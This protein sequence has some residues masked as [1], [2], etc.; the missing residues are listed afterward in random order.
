LALASQIIS[1]G[2]QKR[3]AAQVGI[4]ITHYQQRSA[5][6][7]SSTSWQQKKEAELVIGLLLSHDPRRVVSLSYEIHRQIE[8]L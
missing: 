8:V 4:G 7:V 6:E 1:R 3:L 2:Q 5:E